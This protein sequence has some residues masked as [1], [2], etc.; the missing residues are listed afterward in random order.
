MRN[1][2][3]MSLATLLSQIFFP[4]PGIAQ[5]PVTDDA[6]R[7]DAI[8]L[9]RTTLKMTVPEDFCRVDPVSERRWYE[10][11]A[12][13]LTGKLVGMWTLCE[14]LERMRGGE[15]IEP[16]RLIMAILQRAPDGGEGP[17][18]NITRAY[19]LGRWAEAFNKMDTPGSEASVSIERTKQKTRQIVAHDLRIGQKQIIG[20]DGLAIYVAWVASMT[21]IA[22]GVET[23]AAS[24]GGWSLIEGYRIGH[25]VLRQQWPNFRFESSARTSPRYHPVA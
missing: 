5:E 18:E 21:D 7:L 20:P 13:S 22:T 11:S 12:S 19:A 14:D 2:L 23:P 6:R 1:L 4:N 8:Q 16:R 10:L 9:Q 3:L 15:T 17:I 25:Y 24:V